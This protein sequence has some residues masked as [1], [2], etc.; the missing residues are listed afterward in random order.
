MSMTQRQS[1]II[2]CALIIAS[3]IL[4]IVLSAVAGAWDR[5]GTGILS[6]LVIGLALAAYLRGWAYAPHA[7]VVVLFRS[8]SLVRSMLRQSIV[9]LFL[10]RRHWRWSYSLLPGSLE[11]RLRASS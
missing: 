10:S 7:L 4:Y 8:L 5:V 11:P 9:P 3:A 2:I 6:I 1:F